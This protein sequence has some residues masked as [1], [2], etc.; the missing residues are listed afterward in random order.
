VLNDLEPRSDL[1]NKL[2]KDVEVEIPRA[3]TLIATVVLHSD[4]D[5]VVEPIRFAQDPPHDALNGKSHTRI[6]KPNDSF[7]DP[8]DIVL[9]RL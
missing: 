7:T 1:L 4:K 6:C 8:V 9:S 3:P 5:F 2:L